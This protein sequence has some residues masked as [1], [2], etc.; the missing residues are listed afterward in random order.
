MRSPLCVAVVFAT[1]TVGAAGFYFQIDYGFQRCFYE[2]APKQAMLSI[3][4]EL[5][6]QEARLCIVRV[7]DERKNVLQSTNLNDLPARGRIA[8]VAKEEGTYNVCVDCQGQSWY[9]AV[10]AKLA[11][12]I[13]IAD[14]SDKYGRY[15]HYEVDADTA[16]KKD[17][18]A[19]LTEDLGKFAGK[20]M[21]IQN[22]QAKESQTVRELHD[23]YK[24]MYSSILYFYVIQFLIIG[25]T[26][27]FSVYHITK[28][29]KAYRIV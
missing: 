29:F 16:A 7:S 3:N 9:L 10:T 18:I 13:E 27:A 12:S 22:D 20:I 25:A 11:L 19:N 23:T 8:F 15:T 17:E 21:N 14:G 28:F 4:Y 6:N 1:C 5:V 26:A 2:T 24:S